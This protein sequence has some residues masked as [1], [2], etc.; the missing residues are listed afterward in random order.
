MREPGPIPLVLIVDAEQTLADTLSTA[1]NENGFDARAVYC[2]ETAL[3]LARAL[4]PDIMICELAVGRL[5]GIWLALE[6]V[7]DLPNCKIILCSA[8]PIT[9]DPP[10]IAEAAGCHFTLLPK[11][12][13]TTLLLRQL[14]AV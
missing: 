4:R 10:G 8:E 5:S 3:V 9:P 11:P 2:A 13:D 14:R 12:L 7:Q 1:L 6:V